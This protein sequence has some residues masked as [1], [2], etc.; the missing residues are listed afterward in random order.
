MTGKVYI[1][2]MNMR[3]SWGTPIDDKSIKKHV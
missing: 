2:S 1:S 3:G